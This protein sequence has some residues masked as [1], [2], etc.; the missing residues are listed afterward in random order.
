MT[1]GL[2]ML[3]SDNYYQ[4]VFSQTTSAVLVEDTDQCVCDSQFMEKKFCGNKSV[5]HRYSYD[6]Q[7]S[8]GFC[9]NLTDFKPSMFAYVARDATYEAMWLCNADPRPKFVFLQGGIHNLYNA[10][11]TIKHYLRPALE[12]ID[13]KIRD[14]SVDDNLVYVAYSGATFSSDSIVTKYPWQSR[15]STQNF[16]EKILLFLKS[17]YPRVVIVDFFNVSYDAIL[18]NRTSDGVHTLSD[19]NIIKAMTILNLMNYVVDKPYN[20]S[21]RYMEGMALA[22]ALGI[23]EGIPVRSVLS[24]QIFLFRNGFLRRINDFKQFLSLSL[25]TDNIKVLS[26]LD[27]NKFQFGSKLPI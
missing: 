27:F 19:V 6:T 17:E 12:F 10:D 13:E 18:N 4:G 23:T 1:G 3:Q 21:I 14:C 9:T 15:A 8:K 26:Q 24:K 7:I 22:K 20:S 16:T 5:S 25:D 2:H 11:N